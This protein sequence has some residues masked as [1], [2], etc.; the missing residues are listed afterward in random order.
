MMRPTVPP[1]R[2]PDPEGPRQVSKFEFNLLRIVRFI[3]GNSPPDQGLQLVR[4]PIARPE[5]LSA[6]AVDLVKDTLG[7]ASVLFLVRQGGWRNDRYLRAGSPVPGRVWERIPLEERNLHF[8]AH[9]LSFLIWATAEKAHDTKIGWDVSPQSLTPAD[10][11]FFWRAFEAIRSD[12]ELVAA[13]RQK[14]VFRTNPFCWLFAPGDM[15]PGDEI[16]LPDFSP[17]LEGERAVFLE[18]VQTLLEHRWLRSERTKGQISEW[19]KMRQQGRAEFAALQGFLEAAEKA[20][21]LDLTRFI[22]RTN[23][24]LFTTEMNPMFW[25]GGLQGSGPPRLADRLETQ[26]SALALP[27]L[28]EIMNGWQARARS[29]GFFDTDY[30]ATQMWK[31]EWEALDGDLIAQ[32]ARNVVEML[33]PLR[34]RVGGQSATV[35]GQPPGENTEGN[36]KT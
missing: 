27:R 1:N 9:V 26:R 3:A 14:E 22:L 20:N 13:L 4:T 2:L 28:M 29:V 17:L 19:K 15:V 31:A 6:G 35:G 10:E 5:C 8:S 34:G 21:R 23:A 18:C 16:A 25:T 32:R 24:A 30:H 33:E 12:P 7:K 36:S 11:F